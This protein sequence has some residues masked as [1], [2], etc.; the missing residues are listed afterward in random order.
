MEHL[1]PPEFRCA[2]AFARRATVAVLTAEGLDRLLDYRAPEGG[3]GPGDLVE[4]PLG[5]R[6]VLGVVWGEGQGGF[7]AGKLRDDRARARRAAARGRDARIPRPR[8]RLYA[9]A[10]PDHAA[11]RDPGARARRA[12]VGAAAA[13]ADRRRA[14][15]DDRGARAGA[16]RLRRVRQ[17][18][19]RSGRARASRRR[20]ARRG[21]R[22]RGAGRAGA[23]GS[24]ARRALSAAR[25][26]RRRRGR[27]R[28]PRPRRRRAARR[29]AAG[30]YSTTLLEGRH[31]LGQDRGLSRSR[32]RGAAPRAGRRWCSCPRSRSR[33][34]S[35]TGS[36]RAS[37]PGPPSGTPASPRPRAGGPGSRWRAA[38]RGWWSARARRCSCRSPT[39]GSIVV[40]EEHDGSYKQE[41]GACYHARDMAVLRA[42]IEGAA[43]VLASATPSLES[44]ANA[45][46]GKYARLDLPERFG[47]AELPEMRAIDLRDRPA[48]A[49]ALDL[50]SRWP[51]R[52]TARLAAGEQ[53]LL[54][55]NRRGY[56]PLTICRA[57]GHQVGC[58]AVRRAHGRAPLP[59]AARLPPVRRD[60]A[61]PDRLPGLQ[62][63]G[64]DDRARPRRRAAGRG[65]GA[66][67]GPTPA[68]PSSPPTSPTARAR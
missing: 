48:G 66:R 41:D 46:A 47:V 64:P 19:L 56:A 60:Q 57:C 8:R 34:S 20:V 62:G 38:T 7:D 26:R 12:A 44:W 3:V 2:A 9:D 22:A 63:R 55:L 36:R 42:S 51:R 23:R 30:R 6:R 16:R 68:S 5:P 24:A 10:A 18:R 43:V 31:R 45:E 32:R 67:S 65:G 35:S 1:N 13:A 58:D 49:R 29:R 4:V 33:S 21:R 50:R 61:D 52:S 28:R 17:P 53:A 27:C 15:P 14:R 40:D 59:Q 11:A 39:S 54:F 37:A 25:P